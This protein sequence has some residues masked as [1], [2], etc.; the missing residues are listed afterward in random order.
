MLGREAEGLDDA[1]SLDR[2]REERNAS[3]FGFAGF[4]RQVGKLQPESEIGLVGSEAT[5]RFFV[6]HVQKGRRDVDTEHV[7]PNGSHHSF[8]DAEDIVLDD[9]A[10]LEVDLSEFR[11]PIFTEIFISKA[12]DDLKI[13]IESGDHEELLEDLWR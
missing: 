13:A 2:L 7:F 9:E 10:H 3:S 8:N 11:L 1:S 4:G 5:H 12:P 6:G